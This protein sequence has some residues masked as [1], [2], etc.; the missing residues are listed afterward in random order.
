MYILT[1]KEVFL[2]KSRFL[3][4]QKWIFFAKIDQGLKYQIKEA[5]KV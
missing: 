4:F 1:K 5:G 3:V 2:Q